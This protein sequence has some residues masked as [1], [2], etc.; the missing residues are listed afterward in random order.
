[1]ERAVELSYNNIRGLETETLLGMKEYL[2]NSLARKKITE[3]NHSAPV[4]AIRIILAERGLT[5]N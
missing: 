5:I 4:K 1:M 3:I 2:D